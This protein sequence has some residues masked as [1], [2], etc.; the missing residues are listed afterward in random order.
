MITV[1]DF[2]ISQ[3]ATIEN[4]WH[5]ML[6][7]IWKMWKCQDKYYAVYSFHADGKEQAQQFVLRW[8]EIGFLEVVDDEGYIQ[9]RGPKPEAE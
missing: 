6:N 5:V 9:A 2:K 4:K 1:D 8:A 7:D 3:D